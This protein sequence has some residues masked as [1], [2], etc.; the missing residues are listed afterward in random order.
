M[1]EPSEMTFEDVAAR[2]TVSVTAQALS[3]IRSHA[4]NS[5]DRETGGILLG[6]YEADGNLAV[7]MTATERPKDSISGRTWFQRG[8]R[9]LKELLRERWQRGEYYLGEWHSHPGGSP[10][11]SGNDVREMRAIAKDVSYRCPKPIMV[12]AGRSASGVVTVSLSV[13]E[14]ERLE[15]LNQISGP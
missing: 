9:G 11:P 15:I 13:F 2:F 8:V 1:A 6:R 3:V 4:V 12:I 14:S 7:V 10:N 5:K